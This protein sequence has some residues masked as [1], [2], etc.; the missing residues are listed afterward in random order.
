MNQSGLRHGNS[1]INQR[2]STNHEIFSAFD[3]GLEVRGIFLIISKAFDSLA[4]RFFFKL[5]QNGIC[6]DMVDISDFLRN[7]KQRV[8]LNGLCFSWDDLLVGLKGH[9]KLFAD[10]TFL[11]LAVRNLNISKND[12]NTELQKIHERAHQWQMKFNPDA[13][14]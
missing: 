13:S 14:K 10:D 5:H 9:C 3:I 1:C 2:L 8:V 12:L 7:R 4:R 6:G 11:F